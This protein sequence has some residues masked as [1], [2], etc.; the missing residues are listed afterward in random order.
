M[1][2]NFEEPQVS[3][4]TIGQLL[5][6]SNL[7]TGVNNLAGERDHLTD[8]RSRSFGIGVNDSFYIFLGLIW[9]P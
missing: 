6:L 9:P 1:A 7:C 4:E 3:A 8:D 5:N 2:I